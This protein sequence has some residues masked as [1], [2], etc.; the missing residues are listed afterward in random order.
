VQIEKLF[1]A[2]KLPVSLIIP[3]RNCRDALLQHLGD[4]RETLEEAEEIIG[5]DGESS[6]GTAEVL[7]DFCSA[8]DG[9]SFLSLPPGLYEGWNRAVAAAT[10]PWIYFS[11]V[12][13]TIQP[14]GLESLW[15][16]GEKL[17]AN[18]ILSAPRM[19][20]ANGITSAERKWPIHY[21]A[22]ACEDRESCLT[23]WEVVLGCCS[24]FSG[25][26]LGSSASNLYA[27][28]LLK[29][30]PF[31]TDFG[32][33]GD[34]MWGVQA[35][36]HLRVAILP[37]EVATFTLHWQCKQSDAREQRELFFRMSQTASS[38][39]AT[40]KPGLETGFLQAWLEAHTASKM[41][42]WDWLA[43]Q[44]DLA[45]QHHELVADMKRMAAEMERRWPERIWRAVQRFLCPPKDR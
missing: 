25:S 9:A 35:L 45:R 8:R 16:R 32:H 21:L 18:L 15:Q 39:L 5:V 1:L 26:I 13:D 20:G 44:A 19:V 42:L 37:K 6:D 27:T 43:S 4:V 2:M 31:P 22:A 14:G 33:G 40:M 38:V 11:T 12:G 36:P 3:T 7:R 30:I 29:Q 10:Q 28:S 23:T 17:G 24:F 34:T 41:E